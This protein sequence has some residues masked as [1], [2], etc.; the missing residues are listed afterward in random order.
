MSCHSRVTGKM[1]ERW[2]SPIVK[3]VP[4][5]LARAFNNE[6]EITS[7]SA[8][9]FPV[10][11]EECSTDSEGEAFKTFGADWASQDKKRNVQLDTLESLEDCMESV[12]TTSDLIVKLISKI[13][14]GIKDF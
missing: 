3:P 6:R 10:E 8:T 1:A 2:N 14:K 13:K 4:K 7:S 11:N 9:L 12:M 5:K